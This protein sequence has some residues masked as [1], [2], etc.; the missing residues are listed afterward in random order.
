MGPVDQSGAYTA[1]VSGASGF[2]GTELVKQL[3]EK[4]YNVKGTVRDTSNH[5]KTQ[6]LTKLAEVGQLVHAYL[7]SSPTTQ[8]LKPRCIALMLQALPGKLTLHAAD[9]TKEG[10]FDSILKVT[11]ALHVLVHAP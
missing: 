3:L 7:P 2:I 11:S 10:S 9:L 4:G 1:V 8:N 6:H 5:E